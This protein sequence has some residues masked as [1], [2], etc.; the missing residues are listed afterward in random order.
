[1]KKK[2][3][4]KNPRILCAKGHNPLLLQTLAWEGQVQWNI[5]TGKSNAKGLLPKKSKFIFVLRGS[6]NDKLSFLR[7]RNRA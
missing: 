4:T 6:A 5:T 2:T 1:M 3:V 7:T